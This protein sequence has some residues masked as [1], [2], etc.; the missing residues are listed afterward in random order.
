[1]RQ[2]TSLTRWPDHSE[3]VSGTGSP[4]QTSSAPICARSSTSA[5]SRLLPGAVRRG[6]NPGPAAVTWN[7]ISSSGYGRES[8]WT[9]MAGITA[10]PAPA[11]SSV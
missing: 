1:M 7:R 8:T 3:T 6:V 5:S 11:G 9:V 4:T 10:S 2:R